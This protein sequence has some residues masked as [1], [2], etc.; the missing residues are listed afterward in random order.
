MVYHPGDSLS[1]DVAWDLLVTACCQDVGLVTTA[2]CSGDDLIPLKR[3]VSIATAEI[4][5][6]HPGA[7]RGVITGVCRGSGL[8]RKFVADI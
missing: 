5:E 6:G 8:T 7:E 3:G 1:G 4:S 2:P